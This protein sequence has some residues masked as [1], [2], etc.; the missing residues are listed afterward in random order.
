MDLKINSL[1]MSLLVKD[2]VWFHE[3]ISISKI[4]KLC[5][6]HILIDEDLPISPDTL[7][8]DGT[9]AFSTTSKR[10]DLQFGCSVLQIA[11]LRN[12][13]KLY[14]T[15]YYIL[16]RGRLLGHEKLTLSKYRAGEKLINYILYD[17]LKCKNST[18]D[19]PEALNTLYYLIY[20]GGFNDQKN[21]YNAKGD[22]F[23]VFNN[24]CDITG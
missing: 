11:P 2:F 7:R 21:H 8:I 23:V 20:K 19:I 3:T 4:V 15:L 18:D 16:S 1:K 22:S 10:V 14:S 9:I 5:L 24:I 13:F 12:C 6:P 17:E